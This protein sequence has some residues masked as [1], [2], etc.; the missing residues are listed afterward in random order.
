MSTPADHPEPDPFSPAEFAAWR[1][2]LRLHASVS[3][4][5][6]DRLVAE[7][8]LSLGEYGVLIT[9]VTEPEGLRMTDLAARRLVTPSGISRV[10]DKLERRGL[11]E[12]RTDPAD[13]RGFRTALTAGGLRALRAAQVTHHAAVRA[14]YLGRLSERD[15]RTLARLLEK[16]MPGVV[17]AEIWPAR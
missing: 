12:R 10:V 4:D 6:Q 17:S 13:G 15:Q 7:H 9:L 3:R 5:L 11:V 8:R 14:L 2:L 1:G 16:A